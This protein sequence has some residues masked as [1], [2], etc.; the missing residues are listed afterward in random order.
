MGKPIRVILLIM[1]LTMTACGNGSKEEMQTKIPETAN[2]LPVDRLEYGTEYSENK[3]DT[4]K[5]LVVYFS[6]TGT[7]KLLAQYAAE[8]LGADIFEIIPLEP[9]TEADLAYYTNGRADKEQSDPRARPAILERVENMD[10]Y[11]TI[12][13]CYP[14]WHGQAPKIIY[15]FLES[16]HFSDKTIAPLCTSHSS[17][18]GSSA[19][20]L[21]PLCDASVVWL[22]GQRFGSGTSK[23]KIDEWLRD[24]GLG[25]L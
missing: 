10:D 16:H 22:E 6:C 5:T 14:L 4:M 13:L 20:N 2:Y 17:G 25:N 21:H 8:I 1:L 9:Y 3:E 11:D 18:I 23:N 24:I 12:I 15:T 7:T 19:D